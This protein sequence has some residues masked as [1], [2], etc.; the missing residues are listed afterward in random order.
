MAMK[1]DNLMKYNAKRQLELLER[2][3][4]EKMSLFNEL[5]IQIEM[6]VADRLQERIEE[7]QYYD[8]A[9]SREKR[10]VEEKVIREQ[11]KKEFKRKENALNRELN[12]EY[13]NEKDDLR[14]ESQR[15]RLLSKLDNGYDD[16]YE[17]DYE[18]E[19][20][21]QPTSTEGLFGM[22]V[23]FLVAVLIV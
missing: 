5:D 3:R 16:Y 19:Y 15:G 22:F 2:Q 20:E 17:D 23:V 9:V 12:S 10:A 4:S 21:Q 14:Y 13:K 11:V 18:E 1:N 7:L 6:E 8:G